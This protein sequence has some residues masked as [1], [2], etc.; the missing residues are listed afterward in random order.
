MDEKQQQ[1]NIYN[2]AQL[3]LTTNTV[4]ALVSRSFSMNSSKHS[5]IIVLA[6]LLKYTQYM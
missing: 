4:L 3:L 6:Y 1:N 2:K 5:A